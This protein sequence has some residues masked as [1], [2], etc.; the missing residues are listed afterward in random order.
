[1]CQLLSHFS[2][3]TVRNSG[4]TTAGAYKQD[5]EVTTT[6]TTIQVKR[7]LRSG[8]NNISMRRVTTLLLNYQEGGADANVR[9]NQ[10]VVW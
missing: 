10:S 9:N 5:E 4:V 6:V 7:L 8:E 1:M 3:A 2:A